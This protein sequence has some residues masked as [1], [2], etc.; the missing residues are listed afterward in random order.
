MACWGIVAAES[1]RGPSAL[2]SLR[3]KPQHS[4]E[5]LGVHSPPGRGHDRGLRK[6]AVG[7]KADGGAPEPERVQTKAPRAGRKP[8]EPVAQNAEAGTA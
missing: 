3:G 6:A 8:P 4:L 1:R 2:E 5:L 7:A